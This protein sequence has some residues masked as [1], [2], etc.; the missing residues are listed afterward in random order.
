MVPDQ[1]FQRR[2]R[3]ITHRPSLGQTASP[4]KNFGHVCLAGRQSVLIV[5]E[6]G[7]LVEERP[8]D[9]L[10]PEVKIEGLVQPTDPCEEESG[11]EQEFREAPLWNP[12]TLGLGT[13]TSFC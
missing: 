10:F 2:E 5:R 11:A 13:L 7:V 8:S 6:S 4:D 12:V 3:T 1:C 9:R